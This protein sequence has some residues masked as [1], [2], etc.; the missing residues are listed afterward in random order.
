MAPTMTET[1]TFPSEPIWQTN[2]ELQPISAAVIHNEGHTLEE[3]D[4][5]KID[6]T[7][8]LPQ[9]STT[10]SVV[11]RWNHPRRNISRTFATLFAFLLM[12]ANDAAYGVSLDYY[13][14]LGSFT[15]ASPSGNHSVS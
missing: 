12:G 6:P 4:R 14:V 2:I 10:V 5:S 1:Q 15:H 8:Y 13:Q 3:Q 7:V 9:P 11:E